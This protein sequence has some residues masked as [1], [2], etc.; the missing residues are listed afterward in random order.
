MSSASRPVPPVDKLLLVA[1]YAAELFLLIMVLA[2]HRLGDRTLASSL[3]SKPGIVFVAAL[4][5]FLAAAAIMARR[6]LLSRRLHRRS[7]GFTAAMIARGTPAT[8]PSRPSP[9]SGPTS[10][11]TAEPSSQSSATTPGPST[12]PISGCCCCADW[13]GPPTTGPSALTSS[14]LTA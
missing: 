2:I 13:P 10:P 11:A 9:S 3:G 1:L 8:T 14:R 4:L 12:I 7:L 6:Y 5:A